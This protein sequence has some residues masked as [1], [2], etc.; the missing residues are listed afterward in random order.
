M[1]VAASEVNCF[2]FLLGDIDLVVILAGIVMALSLMTVI[3]AV[4]Y[5]KKRNGKSIRYIV[6][7]MW[8]F[9]NLLSP[10]TQSR[11]TNIMSIFLY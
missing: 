6:K 4:L 11:I 1:Y 2:F 3:L 7:A 8:I 10:L 5:F 9:F